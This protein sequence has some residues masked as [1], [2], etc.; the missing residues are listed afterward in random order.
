MRQ[1]ALKFN[2]GEVIIV[3]IESVF[4][5]RF[6]IIFIIKIKIK[7]VKQYNIND[8]LVYFFV[9]GNNGTVFRIQF[10]FIFSLISLSIY[11]SF[12]LF[13]SLSIYLFFYF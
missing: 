5:V 13:L 10:I 6:L 3:F 4:C 7:F 1:P 2:F 9:E 12:R 8:N 11:L